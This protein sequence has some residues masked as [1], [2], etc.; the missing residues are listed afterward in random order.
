MR[1]V[2]DVP[3]KYAHWV[4]EVGLAGHLV[5]AELLQSSKTYFKFYKRLGKKGHHLIV[6]DL[7]ELTPD[8][9]KVLGEAR[10]SEVISPPDPEFEFMKQAARLKIGVIGIPQGRNQEEFFRLLE[11]MYMSRFVTVIGLSKSAMSSLWDAPDVRV[12]S[13]MKLLLSRLSV[14]KYML[15]QDL[16]SKPVHILGLANPRVE[17]PLYQEIGKHSPLNIR[18][19]S[20]SHP[21]DSEDLSPAQLRR[22]LSTL[23]YLTETYI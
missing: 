18:S 9:S 17:L 14:L 19:V 11:S 10:V 22:A 4:V 1:I 23:L 16:V 13:E 12:Q 7:K 2:V 21:F 6:K 20:T 15:T 5:S 3:F 8:I